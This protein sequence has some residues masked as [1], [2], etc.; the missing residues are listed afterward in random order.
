MIG[1]CPGPIKDTEGFDRLSS[2]DGTI[3]NVIPIQRLGEKIDVAY[4]CLFSASS[5]ANNITGSIIM[6]EGGSTLTF[7]NFAFVSKEFVDGYPNFGKSKL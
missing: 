3:E 5:A 4:A 7:P 1:I 6:V 2:K